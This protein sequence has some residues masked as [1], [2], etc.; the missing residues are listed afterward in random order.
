VCDLE[1]SQ[2][3]RANWAMVITSAPKG[4]SCRTMSK[5]NAE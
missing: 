2:M 3:R 1:M 5:L 4:F